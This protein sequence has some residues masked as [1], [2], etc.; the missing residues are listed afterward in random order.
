MVARKVEKQNVFARLENQSQIQT[1]ATLVKLFVQ[2]ANGQAGMNVRLTEAFADQFESVQ[3]F[4]LASGF[5]DN[6]LEPLSQFNGNHRVS[7]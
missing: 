6:F 7:L 5:F 3:Y 2:L 1:R 4:A